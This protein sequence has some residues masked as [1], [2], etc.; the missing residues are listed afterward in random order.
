[1]APSVLSERSCMV[2]T[3][4]RPSGDLA[5]NRTRFNPSAAGTIV[6]PAGRNN[7]NGLFPFKRTVCGVSFVSEADCGEQTD[8]TAAAPR[9]KCAAMFARNALFMNGM[10]PS[11]RHRFEIKLPGDITW[12]WLSLMFLIP[13]C[14]IL[15]PLH[16]P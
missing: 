10:G 15:H 7:E 16:M 3:K 9:T 5:I 8:V 4:I 11:G 6:K 2:A 14:L 1:M 12:K 13:V